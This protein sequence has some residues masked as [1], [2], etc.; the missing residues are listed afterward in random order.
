MY[1]YDILA[2]PSLTSQPPERGAVAH[3]LLVELL[4]ELALLLH[5]GESSYEEFTRLR[6]GWNSYEE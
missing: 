4:L 5:L 6:L 3:E 1:I 2:Q